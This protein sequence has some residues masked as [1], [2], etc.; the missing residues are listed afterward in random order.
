MAIGF[1]QS[2]SKNA[3]VVTS[4]NLAFDSNVTAGNFIYVSVNLQDIS[5]TCVVTDNL[6]NTYVEIDHRDGAANSIWHFYAKNITGGA[7]TV[8]VTQ[9]TSVAM[10][11][12][13]G[14]YS[15]VDTTAPIDVFGQGGA[16][17]ASISV[18][19]ITTNYSSPLLLLCAR[20]GPTQ[21][22]TAGTNYTVR[23]TQPASILYGYEDFI[24]ADAPGSE[25]GTA[26]LGGSATWD[27]LMVAVKPLQDTTPVVLVPHTTFRLHE[28]VYT[29]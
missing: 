19:P 25:T 10:R 20:W 7:C 26:T 24:S 16:T 29:C 17:S 1:I 4:S 27:A 28:F 18:G 8:T 9:G 6:S 22:F 3:G 2:K 14:E 15:G 21:T 5:T 12:G 13:Q 23:E 11:W